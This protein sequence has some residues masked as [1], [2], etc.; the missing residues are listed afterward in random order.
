MFV[1]EVNITVKGGS[2]GP[3]ALSFH[4]EKFLPKG[5]PD[6]GDGGKGGDVY[7]VANEN[8][9]SLRLYISK[10]NLEAESGSQGEGN[11]RSGKNGKDLYVGVPLGTCIYSD[12]RFLGEI[13][14]KSDRILVAR[15]GRGGR[16]NSN[17][18]S[19]RYRA[20]EVAERGEP[21]EEVKLHLILKS[22]VDVAIVG[23]P[24]RGK[25]LLL[26]LITNA[27][28]K[29]ADY[30]FTTTEPNFGV[31][32]T[33]IRLIRFVDLPAL[34]KD[35][36]N[37]IGLGNKFLRQG[38]RASIVLILFDK[39]EEIEV[40][41]QELGLYDEVFLEKH[42]ITFPTKDLSESDRILSLKNEIINLFNTIKPKA[43]SF[44]H[45]E[46]T[47]EME[48]VVIEKRNGKFY[49]KSKELSRNIGRI[50]F[51]QRDYHLLLNPLF[52][53][54]GILEAL[55]RYGATDGSKIFIED[56]PFTMVEG[57]IHYELR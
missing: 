25:S 56:I 55:K 35:S 23:L 20:P 24:N 32:D 51:T 43:S 22:L 13:L 45:L 49:V 38:E 40:V 21:G 48:P 36:H 19:N 31:L 29:I 1:D 46:Y 16:G 42:I 15:G 11:R 10:R 33:G 37:G 39:E 44:E 47:V 2:G 41:K 34:I 57:R 14:S 9:D 26:S 52:K 53:R 50:D 7:V 8:M 6:G 17:F 27:R 12:N 4:R 54:Y 5:G 30:P 28:P 18:L 3:G